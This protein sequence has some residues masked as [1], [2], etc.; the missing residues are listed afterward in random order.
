MSQPTNPAHLPTGSGTLHE[1]DREVAM[2]DQAIV[3]AKSGEARLVL[4][5]GAAGIG[6][7][8]LLLEARTLGQRAG[9]NVVTA[10][11]NEFERE[12]PFGVVRQLVGSVGLSSDATG[13]RVIDAEAERA[14]Q[15]LRSVDEGGSE[16][17]SFAV[18]DTLYWNTARTAEEAPLMIAVDDLQWSDRPSL[19]FFAYLAR[20]MES[21]PI[22]IVATLRPAES[23]ADAASVRE[24]MSD[25]SRVSVAPKPLGAASLGQMT[26]ERLGAEADPDFALELER[27]TGGNPLLV[28]ELL[29]EL[30]AEKV[31]PVESSVDMLRK[32]GPRAASRSVLLRLARLDSDC[33]LVARAFSILGETTSTATIAEFTELS[34]DA[35]GAAIARNSQAEIFR[36]DTPIG[37]VHPLVR[38]AV[39]SDIPPGERELLHLRAARVLEEGGASSEKVAAQLIHV[40]PRGD[41][42][43]LAKLRH[44]GGIAM[45]KGGISSAIFYLLRALDEPSDSAA[46]GEVLRD[47]GIAEAL[48]NRSEGADHLLEAYELL[49][50]PLQRG[51]IAVINVRL[52]GLAHRND[53]AVD[54]AE[55]TLAELGPEHEAMRRRIQNSMQSI[56]LMDPAVRPFSELAPLLDNPVSAGD[57]LEARMDDGAACYG[58]M[59][60]NDPA[61]ECV[62]I[63]LRAIED[64]QLYK[65]DN[66]GFPLIGVYVTLAV[67]DDD[68][69]IEVCDRS[70]A[71][72]ADGGALYVPAVARGFKGW[73]LTMRGDIQGAFEMLELSRSDIEQFDLLLGYTQISAMLTLA[74]VER[75]TLE[76]AESDLSRGEPY[77]QP[78]VQRIVWLG[79]KLALRVEQGRNQEAFETA[80]LIENAGMDE[81]IQ[82][83]GWLPWRSLKAEAL[84][85]LGR[86]EE[87]LVLAE[88]EVA[89]AR[90]WGAPRALGRALRVL[91]QLKRADGIPDLEEAL[92]LLESS[93][94][95]LEY[96]WTLA[97]MGTTLRHARKQVEA[98]EPLTAALKIASV[99]GAEGLERHAREEL[100]ATGAVPRVKDFQG[101]D[102]LTPSEKRVAGLAVEGMTNREIAQSLFVTPKTVEVHLSNV[103]RKLDVAS[104]RELPGVFSAAA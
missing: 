104:R 8:R 32:L 66:A 7:S 35:V 79:A 64:G 68:R 72:A 99:S 40:S 10:R 50:D 34:Q 23:S 9:F 29:K 30:F 96:G 101:L 20:R 25:P 100:D 98:R 90:R 5:E 93:S 77:L 49:K 82:N 1:R 16:T 43:V 14:D 69:V 33:T 56:S 15:L 26:L 39:Y 22:I 17:T 97:A 12:Y 45:S 81:M 52:L 42:W 60:R 85:G 4:V 48:A 58:K 89:A 65:F 18:L 13:D 31:M 6:K 47:L 86:T 62:P 75:G 57:S 51:F 63:A 36:P 37:F 27:I 78:G 54:L 11:G 53:E 28:D 24:L 67:A 94:A 21:L 84:D 102:S 91:G 83:P 41:D 73:A 71:A 61:S 38:E 76:Q 3:D 19:N 87:A 46:R 103:Y 70:L 88:E 44:A 95:R 92:E 2:L 74:G 59:L 55:R 80:E